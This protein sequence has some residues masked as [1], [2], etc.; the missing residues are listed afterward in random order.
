M[1][2]TFAF[3]AAAFAAVAAW[4]HVGAA[5]EGAA[6]QCVQH[7]PLEPQALLR[8]LSLD[9]RGRIPSI[10]E[11]EALDK[12]TSID[13]FVDRFLSSDEFRLQMRTYHEGMFWPNV[14]NVR[15]ANGEVTLADR[16]KKGVLL[17]TLGRP[18][19][20]RG[21]DDVA[22]CDT[23]REQT[24]FD[25]AFPG[26]FRP[27]NVPTVLDDE[28]KSVKQE[29]YRLVHPY[30]APSTTVK[31]CA[32]DAQ[33]TKSVNGVSCGTR[34][35]IAK[36]ACGCGPNLQWCFGPDVAAQVSTSLREE[37]ARAV[38]DV[39][40][41]GRPYSDLVLSRREHIDGR[42]AFWKRNLAALPPLRISANAPEPTEPL[43]TNPDWSAPW[44]VIDRGP[45][46]AGVL[47]LPV[48]LLKFQTNRG[49]ANRFRIAFMNEHFVPPADPT[50]QAG[51]STDAA[52]LTKRCVCQYCHAK[53]EPMATAF[54]RL[55]EAGS[56]PLAATE[57][58]KTKTSCVGS[59]SEECTRF[60][61]TR[62]DSPRA[63]YLLP[64]EFE[65][66]HAEYGERIE[67]GPVTLAKSIV[68]NGTFARAAIQHLFLELVKRDI[69]AEGDGDERELLA[70]L[71]A[72]F[73]SS[74]HAFVPLVKRIVSLP[75]YRSVR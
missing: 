5:E 73:V 49:R 21:G 74:N 8:R 28:G 27:I 1:K 46:H 6:D 48:Y 11:Y 66:D 54:G 24:E 18:R 37:L 16:G 60:Y 34:A 44:S 47:T 57:Y 10:D 36:T 59:K 69:R 17:L 15:L 14:S 29:G 9:L 68:D 42:I 50:P 33:E 62:A 40:V 72:D 20:F 19:R 2:K 38:D 56:M 53:L 61:V 55:A 4:G 32:F 52:D 67:G 7:H 65:G 35:G 58:P 43:P 26:E 13:N 41:N 64:Y 71:Q 25:P 12:G 45:L 31:V 39:T 51:C 22:S 23:K 3:G 75:Q 30:W 70:D 63:G